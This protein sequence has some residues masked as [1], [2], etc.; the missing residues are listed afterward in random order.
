MFRLKQNAQF[1]ELSKS[2]Y[3]KIVRNDDD[4]A[5]LND[6]IDFS[7]VNELCK[8]F[9]GKTGKPNDYTPEQLYRGALVEYVWE[10]SDRKLERTI[11]N[12]IVAKWFIGL[13]ITDTSFDHSTISRFRDRVG[14]DRFKEIFDQL[15]E[16]IVQHNF[17]RKDDFILVDATH[18][19]AN[20]AL[21]SFLRLIKHAAQKVWKTLHKAEPNSVAR[22]E[23]DYFRFIRHDDSKPTKKSQPYIN[24]VV[25]AT[26]ELLGIAEQKLAGQNF[27]GYW[28]EQLEKNTALLKRVLEENVRIVLDEHGEEQCE[29]RKDTQK[30]RLLSVADPEAKVGATSNTKR[31]VGYR[32][33]IHMT[34]KGYITNV[35]GTIAPV[36][37]Q[38]YLLPMFDEEQAKHSLHPSKVIADAMYGAAGQNRQGIKDRGSFLVSPLKGGPRGQTSPQDVFD[39]TNFV[40]LEEHEVVVCPAGHESTRAHDTTDGGKT[41]V[42][43]NRYCVPCPLKQL[44]G[45][46]RH[47]D[48]EGKIFRVNQYYRAY[49]EAMY[50]S[51]TD[52]YKE[53]IHCTRQ[54]VESKIAELKRFRGLKHC[55]YKGLKKYN[56]QL[57]MGATACNLL[58]FARDYRANCI[59]G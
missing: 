41:L 34:A 56:I 30:D 12:D 47:N 54:A 25:L 50:Y 26:R 13:E 57:N 1:S 58:K 8:P 22:I 9:Y 36:N 40:L 59:A 2:V 38:R 51:D 15:L 5:I 31:F 35:L 49:E 33:H 46:K 16:Q 4:F 10:L 19:L 55:R 11:T 48:T 27:Q 44:C 21:P 53:E 37:E 23:Q 39:K 3:E 45:V 43:P 20:I 32:A 24:K 42:F 6:Q 14:P 7:F 52:A 29:E 28:R 17:I 18:S